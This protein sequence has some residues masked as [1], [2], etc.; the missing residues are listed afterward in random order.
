MQVMFKD[1]DN[2]DIEVDEDESKEEHKKVPP[3]MP[4]NFY[5][6]TDQSLVD[7]NVDFQEVQDMQDQ[8][9]DEDIEY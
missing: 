2:D 1:D 7:D 5:Y 9:W 8:N 3:K 4:H 6:H